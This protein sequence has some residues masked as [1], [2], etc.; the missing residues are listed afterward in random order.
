ML[1][2]SSLQLDGIYP[3][4]SFWPAAASIGTG[5]L[6][7]R[8]CKS[9]LLQPLQKP[10]STSTCARA[11]QQQGPPASGRASTSVQQSTG[12]ASAQQPRYSPLHFN[13]V[14]FC[15]KIVLTDDERKFRQQIV[16]T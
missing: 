10:L 4:L 11:S 6:K 15:D 7:T 14:Q 2:S 13:V 16:E 1:K 5:S 12:A 3:S 9:W 8:S